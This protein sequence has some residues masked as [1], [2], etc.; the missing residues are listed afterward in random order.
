MNPRSFYLSQ[1]LLAGL[2]ITGAGLTAPAQSVDSLSLIDASSNTVLRSLNNNGV[3]NLANDG[4]SLNIRANLSGGS[5]GSVV[6]TLSGAESHTQTE[7]IAP[8]ALKG[9]IR[10]NFNS[11]TPSLG[12]YTL[13][14]QVY[15]SQNGS[16][17]LLDS[18]TINFSVTDQSDTT[19]RALTVVSGSGDGSYPPG[20]IV[21][22]DA[23]APPSGQIFD[24]WTGDIAGVAN[25]FAASTTFTMPAEVATITATYRIPPD[26]GQVLVHGTL[27]QWNKVILDLTGPASSETATPNPFMDYRFQV[28]FTGPNNQQYDVPGFFAGNG[29]GGPNGTTW[30]AF[31]SPDET[32]EWQ[33]EISFRAGSQVA[34]D[35]TGTAGT[36]LTQYDGITGT[37]NVEPSDKVAPD[38]RAPNRGALIN[39]GGH[40]LTFSSGEPFFYAGPGIP[41]NF[42]GYSGFDNTTIGQVHDFTAHEVDWNAG[43]PNWQ[44]ST[45]QD[46]KA[47]IGA[48]NYITEHGG[49]T[50][51]FILMN[52]GGDAKDTFPMISPSE[53]T[54]YD[55]SKL[56]Q[57]EIFF[58]YG[59][60]LGV[61]YTVLL[62]ETEDANEFFWDNGLRGSVGPE[63]KLYYRM[64]SAIMNHHH[65]IKWVIAEE[66]S[67][68]V[69]E[70]EAYM[71]FLKEP[72]IN[73]YDRPVTFH[74]GWGTNPNSY[75]DHVNY[76][77]MD[78]TST[79]TTFNDGQMFS[80]AQKIHTDSAANGE[81]LV[82]FFDEPQKIENDETDFVNGYAHGRR[83]KMWPFFM[84]GGS[85]F[86]WYIQKDGGG[87]GFDQTIEDFSLM[88]SSFVFCQ[89][90]RKFFA[91]LPVSEMDASS[92]LASS[93]SGGPTFTFYK[94]NEVYALFNPNNGG[95]F[96]LDLSAASG[97][98]RVRFFNPRTGEF[99]D[100]GTVNGGGSNVNLGTAPTETDSDWA[101]MVSRAAV[102]PNADAGD[103]QSAVDA[104]GDG[105]ATVILDGS[106]SSDPDGIIFSHTWYEGDLQEPPAEQGT[107]GDPNAFQEENGT[108]VMEAES[109]SSSLQAWE[110]YT[111]TQ[112]MGQWD[113]RAGDDSFTGTGCLRFEGP[114]GRTEVSGPVHS[115]LEYQFEINDPGL[116]GLAILMMESP[117]ET[118]EGDKAN[119]IYVKVNG[120]PGY[121]GNFI[122]YVHLGGSWSW[123]WSNALEPSSHSFE[124]PKY[125]L[126]PGV[127]TLVIAG[128]SKNC[129][130]DRLVL[131]KDVAALGGHNSIGGLNLQNLPE[132]NKG[133]GGNNTAPGLSGIH[134]RVE[135]APGNYTFTLFVEDN[136]GLMDRDT[137]NISVAA[138]LNLSPENQL[139]IMDKPGGGKMLEWNTSNELYYQVFDSLD[140]FR[141][142]PHSDKMQG[143]GNKMQYDVSEHEGDEEHFYR[144]NVS[145]E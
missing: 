72:S 107:G 108:V 65:G 100:A 7:N 38:F 102:S 135:L 34:I 13:I 96:N 23:D 133:G 110:L 12:S 56:Q 16:G 113:N 59:Q 37:F 51:Y 60:Q 52:L 67:S 126:A 123:S 117:K 131:S 118:G 71:S 140:F 58:D 81:P 6:F 114:N 76:P 89:H 124:I 112:Q 82:A 143:T 55:L 39:R 132:S 40:Y 66:C 92:S 29:A 84:G 88:Q 33:Y 86:S 25:V 22:I 36:P 28:L 122:K 97:T 104:D 137:V 5:P 62:A 103:D 141:W 30:R 142:A 8:Y 41:E 53:K 57:W 127:Y 78:T 109:T 48:L 87:H 1:A 32:G 83:N 144:V 85:G 77:D 120:Q 61:Y 21:N 14:T 54:R 69:A 145:T 45:G 63:R 75:F 111:S 79:Q 27:Q 101:V 17:T 3:I 91:G 129:W 24:Q 35:T 98:F 70:R 43:D 9:D 20:T 136:E 74:T 93:G 42:L 94:E 26:D 121:L 11:W 90:I 128:R 80:Y 64:M 31:F 95:A 106:G 49:N 138:G 116:Y 18:L 4:T 44:N 10:G 68:P 134:P 19:P 139:S 115:P 130:I 46:G 15:S 99:S 105:N 125:N 2:F 119:D 73:P 50:I 47:L